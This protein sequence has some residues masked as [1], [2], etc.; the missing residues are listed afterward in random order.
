[1]S[2]HL[3][4]AFLVL[5]GKGIGVWLAAFLQSPAQKPMKPY[6]RHHAVEQ[7]STLG[8]AAGR[9]KPG[10]AWPC[11]PLPEDEQLLSHVGKPHSI[12]PL[13][14]HSCGRNRFL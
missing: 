10:P 5:V 2:N 4:Y 7:A 6:T 12:V 14:A 11:A 8:M 13:G 9:P 3:P 1:M